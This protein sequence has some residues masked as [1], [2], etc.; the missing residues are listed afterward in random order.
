MSVHLPV[1]Q[2][3]APAVPRL[4]VIVAEDHR[5]VF[6]NGHLI[7]RYACYDK[8]IERV[9]VTQLAEVLALPDH[10]IASGFH[11]HPV[12]LSRFRGQLRSG[13]SAALIPRKTGPKG[14]SKVTRSRRIRQAL[15]PQ[16][17]EQNAVVCEVQHMVGFVIRLMDL[18]QLHRRIDPSCQ[19]HG[20]HQPLHQ[21]DPA[22][23]NRA[24]LV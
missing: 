24:H 21:S 13:G 16:R 22:M 3:L 15:G 14:P 20:M 18:E 10:V 1:D 11:M 4:E 5:V 9:V 2:Q 17:V 8:G 23:G 7:S 6:V 12:A 19:S